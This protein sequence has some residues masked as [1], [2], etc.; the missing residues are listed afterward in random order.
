MRATVAVLGAVILSISMLRTAGT[1]A[2]YVYDFDEATQTTFQAMSITQVW[3]RIEVNNFTD[4]YGANEFFFENGITGYFGGLAE[5]TW[6]ASTG[7]IGLKHML[8][9]AIWDF[10]GVPRYGADPCAAGHRI[11]S[12]PLDTDRCNRFGGEGTGSHCGG[13]I[14]MIQGHEYTFHIELALQNASGAGW[15]ATVVDE[16]TGEEHILGAL[17]VQNTN[18]SSHI[19]GYG[20]LTLKEPGTTHHAANQTDPTTGRKILL[21]GLS[22]QEYFNYNNPGFD[23]GHKHIFY[24]SFGWIGPRFFPT[25]SAAQ[26]SGGVEVAATAAAA[27]RRKRGPRSKDAIVPARIMVDSGGKRPDG[28]IT[29]GCIPKYPCGEDR[30]FY[31]AGPE[32]VSDP[33]PGTTRW[34]WNATQ[35]RTTQEFT[36]VV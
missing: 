12:H 25:T 17:F 32:V 2:Y 1:H 4:V 8:D 31:S 3:G 19:A 21:G 14:E 10:C 11:T 35:M 24:S 13:E 36:I 7:E 16:V 29:N 23:P 18:H 22:F 20:G 9:Y 6:N 27:V 28:V 33:P 26:V 5:H 30:V 15:N 34:I